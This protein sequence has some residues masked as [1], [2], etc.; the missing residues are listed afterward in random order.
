MKIAVL[1]SIVGLLQTTSAGAQTIQ[2]CEGAGQRI[3]YANAECPAGTRAVKALPPAPPPSAQSRAETKAQLQRDKD[4]VKTQQ[5]PVVQDKALRAPSS[6]D[7][8]KAA[9][10]GYLQA[11]LDSS[12][13]LRNVLTTRPYYS[14]ED[15]EEADAR[16][17][18]LAA[19]YRR[20]CG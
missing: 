13:Q 20:V 11:S 2:R 9:D 14:T 12:R 7:L 19:E 10:C 17:N 6:S 1:I 3:T 18:E 15:V 16:I 4:A 8:Q 5:K